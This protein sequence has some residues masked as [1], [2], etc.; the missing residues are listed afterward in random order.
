M[1]PPKVSVCLTTYNRGSSLR[2]TINSILQQTFTDFELIIS[3][4]N[5]PD[6]TREVCE[7]Y[8]QRDARVKYFRNES[9]LKM[10]GNLNAAI[11]KATG[12]FVA[13]LHDGDIYRPDLLQKWL[14][15]LQKH[16]DALFVFNAYR[17]VDENG[18]LITIYDHRL[19]EVNDGEVL[20]DY[21]MNT[22]TSAPWGTVMA[23]REAYL[24]Y[25]YFDARYGFISDV[26]M[27]LRLG[28]HGKVCYV[29]EPLIE[30]TPREKT[31]PYYFPHWKIFSINGSILIRYYHSY[32]KQSAVVSRK[33]S[34]AYVRRLLWKKAA[35]DLMILAKHRNFG[36]VSEGL[37]VLNR[38]G[39]IRFPS[40]LIRLIRSNNSR[41]EYLPE[42][43]K[44]TQEISTLKESE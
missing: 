37:D 29:R 21:F 8:A 34:S 5:S 30:L 15:V 41:V 7:Q 2:L 23:R 42:L 35:R 6:N 27:W 32:R 12:E 40:G 22:F 17:A 31:H 14:E 39:V 4:D 43:E 13:N 3:D 9:N 38:A 20:M 16:P 25:G 26:E 10:P 18:K 33:Y 28:L 36:R 19:Q 11:S 1:Q 44:F 24:K